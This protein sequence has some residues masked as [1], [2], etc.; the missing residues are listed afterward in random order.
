[1]HPRREAGAPARYF[2]NAGFSSNMAWQLLNKKID[3]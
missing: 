1:M 2:S 3:Q